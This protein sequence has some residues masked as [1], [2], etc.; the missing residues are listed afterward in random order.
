MAATGH[1]DVEVPQEGQRR[2]GPV[3]AQPD[4]EVRA[5]GILRD[6]LALEARRKQVVLENRHRARLAPGRVGGVAGDQAPQ[7]VTDL[8]AQP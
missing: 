6:A 1:D 3:A 4:E 5:I 2:T 7:Q 8:A